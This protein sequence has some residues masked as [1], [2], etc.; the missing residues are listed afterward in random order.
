MKLYTENEKYDGYVR[1]NCL[2]R[3]EIDIFDKM[4]VQIKYANDVQVSYSLTTYSPY[5]GLTIAFNGMAGRIDSWQDL[6]WRNQEKVD[7]ADRHAREMNQSGE[8]ESSAYDEIYVS[9]N[10]GKSEL[11]QVPF[12]RGGHGGGDKRLQDQIFR[13]PNAPDP[14]KHTAGLRDGAMSI[15]I[16]IAARKSIDEGRPVKIEEL[17]DLKPGV[18]RTV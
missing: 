7:Q 15:L 6:P 17:T 10:F 3:N 4:A 9:D 8:S 13:N 16:G 1:D 5:E 12:L 18:A 11:V 2:W 14:Y